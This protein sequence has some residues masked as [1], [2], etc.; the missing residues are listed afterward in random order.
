LLLGK[1]LALAASYM[2][3]G[4]FTSVAAIVGIFAFGIACNSHPSLE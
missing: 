3:S 2:L 1:K 4:V